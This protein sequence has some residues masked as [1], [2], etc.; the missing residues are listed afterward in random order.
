MTQT[1][2][3]DSVILRAE[4]ITKIYDGTIALNNVDINVY[5]GKVNVLVGENGAGK[6]T[7]MKILA[8]AEQPTAGQL[9]LD[10]KP[11]EFKSPREAT[12]CQIGIIYQEL[13]LFPDLSV[14]ENIFLGHEQKHYG[15]VLDKKAQI[16][17]TKKL[18]QR[19]EQ[20]IDP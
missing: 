7:L 19:L 3:S 13:S 14:A 17:A 5:R 18:M 2:G 11:V 10:G 9:L 16:D 6:S 20:Q 12:A 15:L 4:R 1:E 8:G